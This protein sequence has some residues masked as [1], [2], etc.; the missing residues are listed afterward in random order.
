[1]SRPDAVVQI[2]NCCFAN[3]FFT[4]SAFARLSCESGLKSVFEVAAEI[5]K[6]ND[7]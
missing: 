7:C 1:L 4:G 2:S 6:A 5:K 3:P